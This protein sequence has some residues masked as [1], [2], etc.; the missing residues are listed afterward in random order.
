MN[1]LTISKLTEEE[2][3]DLLE[4]TRWPDGATCPHCGTKEVTKLQG[5]S[6]RPG[7]YKCKDRDCRKQFTITVGTIFEDSHIPIKTWITAFHIMC[8]SK[9]GVSALQLSRQLGLSYRPAWHMAHRIRE[10]MA[11]EPVA[12]LLKGTIEVDETFIGGKLRNMH[13]DRRSQMKKRRDHKTPLVALV[14][15]GGGVR[16]KVVPNV[17][18]VNLKEA[19]LEHAEKSSH[20][21]TDEWPGYIQGT[22][23]HRAHSTVNHFRGEYVR[24]QGSG[25]P[26]A[27]TNTVE[28]FFSLF[29]RGINGAFHHVSKEHLHRYAEE[30]AFRWGHRKETDEERTMA[31]LKLAPM[32]RLQYKMAI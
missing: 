5:K 14:Q 16:V 12:T 27:Y 8:S 24:H 9:K 7:L 21:M 10:A 11:K 15:R 19:L 23:D 20:I 26:I 30:F 13:A 3:R 17:R 4:K 31:A 22:E 2:A 28:S 25:L 18:A 32:A 1:L 6:T 29:K